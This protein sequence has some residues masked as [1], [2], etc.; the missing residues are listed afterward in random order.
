M[1]KLGSKLG[2]RLWIALWLCGTIEIS[3]QDYLVIV[4][5]DGKTTLRGNAALV[6]QEVSPAS[7][8]K[9]V[10]SWA[11]LDAGITRADSLRMVQD[12][13]VPRTPR[14]ITLTQAM[15]YSSNDYFKQMAPLIGYERLRAQ[16]ES[17][18]LFTQ[19]LIKTWLARDFSLVERG[20]LMK[21]TPSSNHAWMLKIASGDWI[22][23]KELQ[24]ALEK[25]M[26]WPSP[27]KGTKLFG[28]TGTIKG[29]VW[30]NGFGK[31][32]H[33]LKVVTVFIPGET[34][35]RP[36]AI[37]LF[38]ETFGLKWDEVLAKEME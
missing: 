15:F 10:L 12:A 8:F 18:G 21:T 19:P 16:V 36:R 20:G 5:Q 23:N 4:T 7:T 25:T 24:I 14:K 1:V 9:V 37:G 17:T 28:K 32:A 34:K 3:A 38:Y 30:F 29:A 2:L 31:T 13:H 26:F 33:G 35:D 6:N 22:K 11:A 27:Q